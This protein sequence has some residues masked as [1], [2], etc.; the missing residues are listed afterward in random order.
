MALT[1]GQDVFIQGS[2]KDPYRVRMRGGVVDC[3]CPGWRNCPG[4]LDLKKCKH[5]VKVMGGSPPYGQPA[6]SQVGTQTARQSASVPNVSALPVTATQDRAQEILD[7]AAS[8]GRKLRQDEKAQ[9]YGP[10]VLLAHPF[11]N[12]DQDP[13]G[14]LMSEKLDGVRA[15]WDGTKFISRQGNTF[16]APDWFREHLPEHLM[17]G[18]LWIGRK[19]FQKTISVVKRQDWGEGARQVFYCAFDLP[20]LQ[21]PFE[22]RYAQLEELCRTTRSKVIRLVTQV[23]CLG[24]KHLKQ[25]LDSVVKL[26]AEGLMVRNPK[27]LY[28]AGRSNQIL[29]VKPF[30]TE[31]AT[32]VGYEA[33]KGRLKGMTGSLLVQ[34]PDGKT[35]N[36]GSGL[37]DEN[38]RN[39]PKLGAVITYRFTELTNDGIPKCGSFV[40]ERDYE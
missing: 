5:T 1:E 11:E 33:G 22:E 7:H 34:M 37:S 12:A 30:T 2:G 4:P 24:V 10:P 9:L 19:M 31:E 35:F 3:S 8:K 39:P 29:K 18:E 16:Y 15:W 13:S 25:E 27:S 32:V 38:R 6:L 36:V 28:E 23:P 20:H 14:W 21:L 17:D 40:C 26:G